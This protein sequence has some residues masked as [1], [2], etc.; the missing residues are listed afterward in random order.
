MA[1]PVKKA[2]APAKHKDTAKTWTGHSK[3]IEWFVK[4]IAAGVK[5][6]E[7]AVSARG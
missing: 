4:A 3:R 7:I 5:A 6:E 1:P 2:P